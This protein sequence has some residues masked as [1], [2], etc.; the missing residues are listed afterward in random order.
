MQIAK[1]IALDGIVRSENANLSNFTTH[2]PVPKNEFLYTA[3]ANSIVD[4]HSDLPKII[5]LTSQG[6]DEPNEYWLAYGIDATTQYKAFITPQPVGGYQ[7]DYDDYKFE[8]LEP[9]QV[10]VT[11][12]NPFPTSMVAQFVMRLI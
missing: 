1:A 7:Y 12:T 3:P 6:L 11:V 8:V 2:L 9:A 10:T 5:P 4:L